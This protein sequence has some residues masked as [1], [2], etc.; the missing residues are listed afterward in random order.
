MT[1]GN[2]IV[3][4]LAMH[5]EERERLMKSLCDGGTEQRVCGGGVEIVNTRGEEC[6]S[7][8][9]IIH[10]STRECHLIEQH[11]KSIMRP[12]TLSI[13]NC[14][15]ERADC[16]RSIFQMSRLLLHLQRG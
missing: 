4:S 6:A 5:M 16:A 2:V 1:F 9:F 15:V 13:L 8:T 10:R 11:L 14:K 3:S 7:S 12:I